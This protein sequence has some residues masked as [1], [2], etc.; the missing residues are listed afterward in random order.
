MQDRARFPLKRDMFTG[1]LIPIEG[2]GQGFGKSPR[3]CPFGKNGFPGEK[4]GVRG[5]SGGLRGQLA[6]GAAARQELADPLG[7]FTMLERLAQELHS[8]RP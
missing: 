6:P 2:P 5:D 4:A 7:D 1:N 8:G 3:P